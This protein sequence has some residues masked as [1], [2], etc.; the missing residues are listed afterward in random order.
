MAAHR[1]QHVNQHR[2]GGG[3]LAATAIGVLVVSCSGP[4]SD[5]AP[6]NA[7]DEEIETLRAE[8]VDLKQ[9]HEQQ[10]DQ[11]AAAIRERYEVQLQRARSERES[12]EEALSRTI[13]DLRGAVVRLEDR[14]RALTRPPKTVAETAAVEPDVPGSAIR[15]SRFEP[16]TPDASDFILVPT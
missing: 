10:T 15:I 9:H 8:I 14:I 2:F 7:H 5:P 13:E 16:P 3:I 1:K 12:K 4:T 6:V 11:L